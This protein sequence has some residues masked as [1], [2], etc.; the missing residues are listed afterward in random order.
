MPCCYNLIRVCRRV[1]PTSITLL[2]PGLLVGAARTGHALPWDV[3][4]DVSMLQSDYSAFFRHCEAT[5]TEGP[6]LDGNV[7]GA[8]ACSHWSS[9]H[10]L[11][12]VDVGPY[13][14]PAR[15]TDR[16]T[17]FYVDVFVFDSVPGDDDVPKLIGHIPD[18]VLIGESVVFPLR[19]LA[20]EGLVMPVPHEH[21]PYLIATI[22]AMRD[23]PTIT[24]QLYVPTEYVTCHV[25]WLRYR[26]AHPV[27]EALL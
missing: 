17:G 13:H 15:A 4:G 12:H 25:W 6:Y 1:S 7:Q 23:R 18:T 24:E 5:P 8:Y 22:N 10:V 9:T 2:L 20:V 11:I 27:L 14:I 16:T 19:K 21:V 26:K 3:D